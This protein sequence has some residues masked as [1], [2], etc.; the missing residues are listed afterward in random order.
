MGTPPRACREPCSS[1]ESMQRPSTRRPRRR[2]HNGPGHVSG[3]FCFVHTLAAKWW[4]SRGL[5]RWA[6]SRCIGA[7][8]QQEWPNGE[9]AATQPMAAGLK[10]DGFSEAAYP[11]RAAA[12]ASA[13][14]PRGLVVAEASLGPLT[15][16]C[17]ASATPPTLRLRQAPLGRCSIARM[18]LCPR[19]MPSP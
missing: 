19:H 10:C 7:F 15:S 8:A 12:A 4:P 2:S 9:G 6:R 1:N 3:D 13:R 16:L 18:L 11:G 14:T 17:R 5:P